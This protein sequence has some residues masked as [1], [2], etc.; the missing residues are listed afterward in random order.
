MI[1]DQ[2]IILFLV[3]RDLI[4]FIVKTILSEDGQ[5]VETDSLIWMDIGV[6]S[7]N[8]SFDVS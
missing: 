3:L 6:V 2:K 8:K 5:R 7:L 1:T 4:S